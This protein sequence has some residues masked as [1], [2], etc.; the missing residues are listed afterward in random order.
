MI[1]REF[2]EALIEFL[3]TNN[4]ANVFTASKSLG[5]VNKEEWDSIMLTNDFSNE[6]YF[7][8]RE[9]LAMFVLLAEGEE[10]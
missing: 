1:P 4:N 6:A 5:W 9:T 10:F 2:I 8:M 7:A 3:Q